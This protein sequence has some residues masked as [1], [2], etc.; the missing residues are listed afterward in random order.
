MRSKLRIAVFCGLAFLLA[1]GAARG[2]E[3]S[4]PIWS[5]LTPFETRTLHHIE[6]ARAGDADTLLAL[7]LIASGDIRDQKA[8]DRIRNRVQRFI[9]THRAEILSQKSVYARGEKLLHAMHADFFAG[10]EKGQHS[11]LI[12]GYDAEQSQVSGIFR[13]GRFNCISSAILY[14]VLARYFNLNV[15]GVV[16][17]QHAFVQ[18][19]GEDGRPIEVE[20]TAYDGYGLIHDAK[21]YRTRF[22]RFSLSRNLSVPTYADYLKRRVLPPYRFIAE[23]MNQQHTSRERMKTTDRRRLSEMMGYIDAE[24]A[25]SQ[26][27]RLNALNNACIRLVAKKADADRMPSVLQRVLR[28]VQSRAWIGYTERP[29]VARIWDRIGALHLMLGHLQLNADRFP[30]ARDQYALALKWSRE[31]SLR[32]QAN[33]G[34]LNAQVHEAFDD[35]RWESAIEIYSKLLPL[36]DKNDTLRVNITHDNIATAY[37]NWANAAAD[38]GQWAQAADRYASAAGW[39]R[40]RD[41]RRRAQSAKA[42]AEAMHHLQNGEWDRAIKTFKTILSGQDAAGRKGVR[43]NIGSAYV[44]WGNALFHQQAYRAA[45][46]KFEAAL[47]MLRG[48]NRNLVIRNI[49]AAYHNM[50]IPYLN[51]HH[52]QKAVALLKSAT[53]R[54]PACTPC[55]QELRDLQQRLKDSP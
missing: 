54:F 19:R 16:T 45:L 13:D 24:S 33:I 25:A 22:T 28:H 12:G 27:I 9:Q 37:W 49:A 18:I 11:E 43:A 40:N 32:K 17:S 20:T 30:A 4:L 6:R 29:E 52:P 1:T 34:L 15:E 8:Y 7:S 14:I 2:V 53:E 36:L 50:T 35:H 42:N 41:A 46:D 26:L 39:A 48:E 38:K 44:R 3:T 21:F 55:R 10:G 47:D 51:A 5:P 23:N 31:K